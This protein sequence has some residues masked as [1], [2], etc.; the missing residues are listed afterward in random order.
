MD[1]K[2]EFIRIIA[3]IAY[4]VFILVL[5]NI[6]KVDIWGKWA[7]IVG[8]IALLQLV[9]KNFSFKGLVKSSIFVLIILY[10]I[11]WLSGYGIWGYVLTM[12][13]ITAYILIKK[14]KGLI[15]AK[16]TIEE[17]IWGEPL[18]NF[19]ERGERPPKLELDLSR[20]KK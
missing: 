1:Y 19:I 3:G 13:L 20:K 10:V 18:K 4:I 8:S 12:A 6:L 14:W 9:F 7:I 16:Q 5:I 2:K 17:M 11:R 15:E